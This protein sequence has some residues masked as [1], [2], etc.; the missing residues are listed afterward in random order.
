MPCWKPG[1]RDALWYACRAMLNSNVHGDYLERVAVPSREL[2]SLESCVQ[3]PALA[4]AQWEALIEAVASSDE[5]TL[6][7]ATEALE[8]AG[9]IATSAL[10]RVKALIEAN[11][12]SPSASQKLYWLCTLAGRYGKQGGA[13]QPAVVAVATDSKQD[14]SVRERAVWCLGE[15]GP[16]DPTMVEALKRSSGD[17]TERFQRLIEAATSGAVTA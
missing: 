3:D 12:K 11:L 7:A 14:W 5:S 6:E 13:L 16:I 9:P 10:P 2:E 4:A 1:C 15:I 17:A 8:N